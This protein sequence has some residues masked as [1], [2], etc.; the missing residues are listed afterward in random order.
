MK[1][2][3]KENGFTYVPPEKR[4]PKKLV[5]KKDDSGNITVSLE[6]EGLNNKRT[7]VSVE[8]HAKVGKSG[9]AKSRVK[10]TYKRKRKSGTRKANRKSSSSVKNYG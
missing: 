2:V 3:A 4:T 9:V 1:A 6:D 5:F 10:L 7:I 8:K